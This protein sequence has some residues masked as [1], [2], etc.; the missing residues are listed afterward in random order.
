M[1]RLSSMPPIVMLHIAPCL[2]PTQTN[3]DDVRMTTVTQTACRCIATYET[4][5]MHDCGKNSHRCQHQC[6]HCLSLSTLT[7]CL[8]PLTLC[9]KQPLLLLL[10]MNTAVQ[11]NRGYL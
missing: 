4:P 11:G 7:R 9:A 2:C 3:P 6:W 8:A 5:S 1:D 10:Y